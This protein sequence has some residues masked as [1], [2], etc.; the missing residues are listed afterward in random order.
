MVVV[1]SRP[2]L[3]RLLHSTGFD[4]IVPGTESLEEGLAAFGKADSDD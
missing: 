3:T 4:Q 2:T 1:C